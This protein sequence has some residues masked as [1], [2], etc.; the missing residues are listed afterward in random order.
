MTLKLDLHNNLEQGVY[1]LD[2]YVLF[3][4]CL[5]VCVCAVCTMRLLQAILDVDLCS[6]VVCVLDFVELHPLSYSGAVGF[7]TALQGL[8]LQVHTR[9]QTY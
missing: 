4:L 8:L 7:S 9:T 5:C 6:A 3:F 2:L 1:T